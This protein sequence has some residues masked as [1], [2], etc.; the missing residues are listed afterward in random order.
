MQTSVDEPLSIIACLG[1]PTQEG[2][3]NSGQEAQDFSGICLLIAII[4]RLNERLDEFD[5]HC[6]HLLIQ[7]YLIT[8]MLDHEESEFSALAS[9]Y[10]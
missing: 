6:H 9:E 4:R 7:L 1:P 2:M 5:A 8:Y 10:C 3:T